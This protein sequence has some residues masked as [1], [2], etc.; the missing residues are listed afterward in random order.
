MPRPRVVFRQSLVHLTRFRHVSYVT[1]AAD[2]A[3]LSAVTCRKEKSHMRETLEWPFSPPHIPSSEQ[4]VKI[5]T[6]Q[7]TEMFPK[8][9]ICR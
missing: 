3:I 6:N 5:F 9:D 4:A 8:G 2:H 7:M 1:F